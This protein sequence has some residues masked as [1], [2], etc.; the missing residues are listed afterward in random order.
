M[1][2]SAQH[3]MERLLKVSEE[4]EVDNTSK[5][6]IAQTHIMR[7]ILNHI[8]GKNNAFTIMTHELAKAM[9]SAIAAIFL[10]I[11]H[12][13]KGLMTTLKMQS[14]AIHNK[15][16]MRN[17]STRTREDTKDIMSQ[18]TSLED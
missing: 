7:V 12:D 16:H 2:N 3:M 8:N 6:H 13:S 1:S 4:P 10:M 11:L 15:S 5:N 18:A 17:R 9:N 14:I